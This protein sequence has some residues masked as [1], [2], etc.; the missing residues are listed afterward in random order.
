VSQKNFD[1]TTTDIGY[2]SYDDDKIYRVPQK[3]FAKISQG[4][5]ENI[6]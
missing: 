2:K 5:S 1:K 3:I 4:V 6:C